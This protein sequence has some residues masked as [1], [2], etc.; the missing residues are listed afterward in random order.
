VSRK[1]VQL[2]EIYDFVAS[3]KKEIKSKLIIFN[4]SIA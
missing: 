2:E 3:R 4:Y 1:Q